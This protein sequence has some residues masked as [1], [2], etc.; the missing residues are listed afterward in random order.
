MI[1]IEEQIKGIE[2]YISIGKDFPEQVEIWKA[3]LESLK[4]LKDD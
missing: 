2:E 3:I 4:K 1:S